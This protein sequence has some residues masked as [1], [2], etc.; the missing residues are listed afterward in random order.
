MD[1]HNEI[2]YLPDKET[3]SVRLSPTLVNFET[4]VSSGSNGEGR[5]TF[6]RDPFEI[7]PSFRPNITLHEGPPLCQTLYNGHNIVF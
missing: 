7:V 6:A 5:T 4:I 2:Q 3:T 1:L